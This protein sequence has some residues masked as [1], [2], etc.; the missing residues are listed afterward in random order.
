M[1]IVRSQFGER[2]SV[3]V[4]L[5]R[6]TSPVLVTV[7]LKVA[8]LPTVTVCDFGSLTIEI[9]GWLTGVTGGGP[10]VTAAESLALTSDPT[11]GWP[12]ATATLVKSAVTL[13]SVQL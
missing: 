8:V 5:V 10:T 4:T 1:P 9:A 3:T 13:A 12:V 6:A 7:I 11:D 2:A